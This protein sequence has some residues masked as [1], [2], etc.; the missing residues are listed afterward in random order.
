MFCEIGEDGTEISRGW[1]LCSSKLCHLSSPS[2]TTAY[3]HRHPKPPYQDSS[4]C[5][6]MPCSHS[7]CLK[8][9]AQ[10]APSPHPSHGRWLCIPTSVLLFIP[11]PSS[12]IIRP[13]T[14]SMNPQGKS[15][16]LT[17]ALLPLDCCSSYLNLPQAPPIFDCHTSI[18]PPAQVSLHTLP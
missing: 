15:L 12:T 17:C 1:Q 16:A 4:F 8:P 14:I 6:P 5:T 18:A 3:S 11:T 9:D 10:H 13:C 2:V 7:H